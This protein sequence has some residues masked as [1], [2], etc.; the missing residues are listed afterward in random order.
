MV[1]GSYSPYTGL[2]EIPS[3]SSHR[4]EKKNLYENLGKTLPSLFFFFGAEASLL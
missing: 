3:H 2:T 1:F 4:K